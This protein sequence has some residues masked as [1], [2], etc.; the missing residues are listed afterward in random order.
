MWVTSYIRRTDEALRMLGDWHL[1]GRQFQ[2]IQPDFFFTTLQVMKASL[3]NV[4]KE[5]N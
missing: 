1:P 4:V 3:G 5:N 2:L